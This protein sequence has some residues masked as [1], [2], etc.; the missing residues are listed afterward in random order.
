MSA[1]TR[2]WHCGGKLVNRNG[3]SNGPLPLI[4]DTA[5]DPL[6]NPV[7]VHKRCAPAP[8]ITARAPVAVY[9]HPDVAM[10]QYRRDETIIIEDGDDCAP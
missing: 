3:H 2:C 9:R 6:G 8:T 5:A 7:R 10:A 1:S 4:F